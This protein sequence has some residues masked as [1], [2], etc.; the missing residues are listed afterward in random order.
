M[1]GLSGAALGRV[2]LEQKKYDEAADALQRAMASDSSLREA[3]YYL[4]MTY[5]RMGR[6]EE[7]ENQFQIATQLEKQATEKQRTVFKILNPTDTGATGRP[8]K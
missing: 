3:H 2:K 5:A 6:K 4:G 1:L 7:S 8:Q